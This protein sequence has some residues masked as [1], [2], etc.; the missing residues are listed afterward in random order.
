MNANSFWPI[1][2][3]SK[4][5]AKAPPPIYMLD[6]EELGKEALDHW[7][8]YCARLAWEAVEYP[9]SPSTASNL[10]ALVLSDLGEEWDDCDTP[11]I[12][13][14]KLAAR[15]EYRRAGAIYRRYLLAHDAKLDLR[16]RFL[17][18]PSCEQAD[19]K[20]RSIK[21]AAE[22]WQAE[23]AARRKEWIQIGG[24]LRARHPTMSD[25]RLSSLIAAKS[26]S[27]GS[28]HAIRKALGPLGL[29]RIRP[30]KN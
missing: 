29:K 1:L 28:A 3:D 21:K 2:I 14:V 26:G 7:Y 17:E 10:K 19:S 6:D 5:F 18:Y 13:A 15:G 25:V 24:P 22:K 30:G 9:P 4:L 20:G 16:F 27:A 23:A 11:F 12:L 8:Q